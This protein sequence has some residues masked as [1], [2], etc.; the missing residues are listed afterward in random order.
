MNKD[1]EKLIN[2]YYRNWKAVQIQNS[3]S[4]R[5]YYRVTYAENKSIIAVY[6]PNSNETKAFLSFTK[7]F[8]KANVKVPQ[9]LFSCEEENVYLL[10][11][12]GNVSLFDVISTRSTINL[13]IE[14]LELC[15]KA[16][17]QLLYVQFVAS[18]NID[19]SK[20]YP[21]S[22]MDKESI[23]WDLN[24]FKYNFLKL[25]GVDF[26]E[27]ALEKDFQNL[28]GIIMQIQPQNFVYRD[29]Q[30]R[31]I[32]VNDNGLWFI[33]Y[34]GGR[35][36]PCVYDLASFLYQARANFTDL[37]RE[38]LLSHY[39][40]EINQYLDYNKKAFRRDVKFV[41]LLRA[42]QTLGAYGFRGLIEKKPHFVQSMDAGIKNFIQ[43]LNDCKKEFLIFPE[44]NKV[45]E[46]LIDD[47]FKDSKRKDEIVREKPIDLK[48]VSFSYKKN[49]IPIDEKHG[50]GFVFDC[51]CLPNPYW[52]DDL[53]YLSGLDKK[54]KYYFSS[55]PEV[56][57][58]LVNVKKI[59]DQT[60]DNYYDKG[61]ESLMISFGCTGGKHRSVYCADKIAS[62]Y[63]GSNKVK[64]SVKHLQKKSW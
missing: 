43:A 26:D 64:A 53:K 11:D 32:M 7:T 22:R 27:R 62:L 15:Y 38:K 61:Y 55:K 9:I 45:I 56:D 36:G 14:T 1:L 29:F 21:A 41:R 51:R 20:A 58:F 30:S 54:V 12:L 19:Y 50:G 42:M 47:N 59:V 44:I 34:Q 46:K 23:M 16:I 40:N 31:N 5:E 33:D 52:E 2:R 37:D 63:K 60:V 10:K 24:Y 28:T 48:I 35:K 57:D 4:G 39:F 25:T 3:G 49:G 13:N 17:S 18:K 6:S 8:E